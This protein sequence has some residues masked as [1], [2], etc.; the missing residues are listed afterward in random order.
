MYACMYVFL[1]V[2]V[3]MHVCSYMQ[4]L[5]FNPFK[6][7]AFAQGLFTILLYQTHCWPRCSCISVLRLRRLVHR[8]SRAMQSCHTSAHGH[9]AFVLGTH[10]ITASRSWAES[11][12]WD[13]NAPSTAL[14]QVH[15]LVAFVLQL[16]GVQETSASTPNASSS[17]KTWSSPQPENKFRSPV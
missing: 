15:G 12:L 8:E 1:C 5:I 14:G 3:C 7:P 13:E 10:T 9:V 17:W 2:Y 4:T 11:S 6:I 16:C